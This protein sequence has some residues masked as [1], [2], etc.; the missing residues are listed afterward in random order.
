MDFD[1]LTEIESQK[2]IG[3]SPHAPAVLTERISAPKKPEQPENSENSISG[4]APALASIAEFTP[5]P[6]PIDD[7]KTVK[8]SS[9]IS[10]SQFI[11]TV[12]ISVVATIVL[13]GGGAFGIISYLRLASPANSQDPYSRYRNLAVPTVAPVRPD[14]VA[15][16]GETASEEAKTDVDEPTL[17]ASPEAAITQPPVDA[18]AWS[19]VFETPGLSLS[20]LESNSVATIAARVTGPVRKGDIV[21]YEKGGN[22]YQYFSRS[23]PG[24]PAARI[25]NEVLSQGMLPLTCLPY[26]SGGIRILE[27]LLPA[28]SCTSPA[29]VIQTGTYILTTRIYTSCTIDPNSNSAFPSECEQSTEVVSTP[30]RVE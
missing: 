16:I 2:P 3:T 25:C 4:H 6:V 26:E 19:L 17:E 7:S 28:T 15:P 24:A 8:T 20:E 29:S 27:P 9:R 14:R 23:M 30:F 1:S 22:T 13:V 10:T 18:P 12:I 11:V 5:P 21:C